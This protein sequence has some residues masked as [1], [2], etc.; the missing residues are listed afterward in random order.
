[1]IRSPAS[2]LGPTTASMRSAVPISSSRSR[3]RLGAPPCSGPDRA[4]TAPTTQAPT[5]APV[6][7]MTRAVKVEALK[8]WSMVAMRYCSSAR[9]PGRRRARCR[10]SSRAGWRPCPGRVAARSGRDRAGAGRAR[11]PASGSPRPASG[12]RDDARPVDV[13][14]RPHLVRPRPPP[15]ARCAAR[16][17]GPARPTAGDGASAPAPPTVGHHPQRRHLAGEGPALGRRRAGG[18]RR[19]GTRRPRTSTMLG[20]V[21]GRVLAVVVE[22]LAAPDVADGGVGD[23]H[24]LEAGRDL[25]EEGLRSSWLHGAALDLDNQR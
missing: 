2:S 12:R 19:T 8:P 9:A 22:A 16:R 7:A 13:E 20:Q 17:A 14:D 4:P 10:R 25:D 18:P 1:M 24:P 23:G 21:D 6:E 5:S 15:T 11:P 3:A